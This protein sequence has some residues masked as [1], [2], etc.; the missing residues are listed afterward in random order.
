MPAP[1]PY[2]AVSGRSNI[3]QY[4]VQLYGNFMWLARWSNEINADADLDLKKIAQFA[5]K[6]CLGYRKA[7]EALTAVEASAV[8]KHAVRSVFAMKA[9]VWPTDAEMLADL[10]AIYNACGTIYNWIDA[11]LP[12]AKS[13]STRTFDAT[14]KET[15][16]PLTIAKPGAVQT[17]IAAFRA[18]FA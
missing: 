7:Y 5:F 17:R 4:A 11:N 6:H 10:A 15:E 8:A 1:F 12:A 13:F 18:L 9:V 16:V 14:G 2:E 3:D